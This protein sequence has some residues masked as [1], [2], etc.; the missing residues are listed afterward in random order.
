MTPEQQAAFIMA[1]AACAMAEIA[2]MQ[3]ANQHRLSLG[4]TIAYDEE[5]FQGVT[6]RNVIGHSDVIAFFTGRS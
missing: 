6:A 1:Q 4:Q 5:A 2:G 3:A